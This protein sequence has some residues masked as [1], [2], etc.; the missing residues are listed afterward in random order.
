MSMNEL[1]RNR[2]LVERLYAEGIN[3]HD[4]DAAAAV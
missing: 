4:A 2:Q 3:R 1:D